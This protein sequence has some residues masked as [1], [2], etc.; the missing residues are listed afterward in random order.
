MKQ[1]II[2]I[3]REFGSG[4]RYIGEAVAKKLNYEYYDKNI[5]E[6]ISEESGLSKDFIKE[7]GEYAP[8]KSKFA[9]SFLSRT[10]NGMALEDYIFNIQTGIIKECASK[11]S[12]VIIGRCADYILKDYDCFNV[13][14][15][16][17]TEIK[18]RRIM[19]I[20][21]VSDEEA[22]K[23]MKETDERR[24]VNYNY[25]TGNKWGQIHNY[26]LSL[27]SSQ[28]GIEKCIDIITNL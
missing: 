26:T 9:Y 22:L 7:A 16:G 14:I 3:S 21:D 5:I 2:T 25:C 15:Y 17:D 6:R 13:F 4:G 27:N 20:Y 18:K 19:E 10:S 1:K 11:K 23:L 12:C 24:K 8:S 28:I